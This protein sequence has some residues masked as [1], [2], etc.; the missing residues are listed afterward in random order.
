[1]KPN[2]SNLSR[3]IR[4]LTRTNLK[5]WQKNSWREKVDRSLHRNYYRNIRFSLRSRVFRKFL[6]K[7]WHLEKVSYHA[8]PSPCNEK[9]FFL[10]FFCLFFLSAFSHMILLQVHEIQD[11]L[12]FVLF[13]IFVIS[14][15]SS[16]FYYY[17][18]FEPH[19]TN[20]TKFLRNK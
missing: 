6:Y 9:L 12:N 5:K 11:I 17:L 1:M 14:S 19:T 2:R 15:F 16:T 7:F 8:A 20:L 3:P 18:L 13:F 10:V 4:A